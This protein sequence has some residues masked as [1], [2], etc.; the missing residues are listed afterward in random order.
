[1]IF[2]FEFLKLCTKLYKAFFGAHC[3]GQQLDDE[4]S[5]QDW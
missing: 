1:M 4:N 2:L 3:M 5:L